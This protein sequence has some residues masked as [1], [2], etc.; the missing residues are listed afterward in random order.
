LCCNLCSKK[1]TLMD[2]HTLKKQYRHIA[3]EVCWDCLE[4]LEA[5]TAGFDSR[6]AE[7][8][9]KAVAAAAEVIRGKPFGVPAPKLE[10]YADGFRKNVEE[11]E[12]KG[13]AAQGGASRTA[14]RGCC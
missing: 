2:G 13:T 8:R 10:P 6:Q 4:A 3:D 5:A 12:E 14:D 11:G 9:V 7:E 1:L